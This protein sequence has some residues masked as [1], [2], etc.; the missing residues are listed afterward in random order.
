MTY[1][2]SNPQ[3]ELFP[4]GA[5]EERAEHWLNLNAETR[6]AVRKAAHLVRRV[7]DRDTLQEVCVELHALLKDIGARV[8]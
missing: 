5:A 8:S 1:D 2:E 4:H 6:R 7:V 3:P